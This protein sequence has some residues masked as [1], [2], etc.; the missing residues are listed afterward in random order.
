MDPPRGVRSLQLEVT[1][2]CDSRAAAL[3][4]RALA[5]W[6][7]TI[8]PQVVDDLELLVS[9]LIAN[10]VRHCDPVEPPHDIRLRADADGDSIRVEVADA[11]RGFT[12]V[13]REPDP[14]QTGGRG[15]Y[16]VDV[17]ADRWGIESDPC[18]CVWFELS[19]ELQSA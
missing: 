15:L 12:H 14:M 10:S 7:H 11:G 6:A 1:L 17:L 3:A 9:E 4:R 8:E 2:P 19:R 13:L 5:V 18:T 16:M